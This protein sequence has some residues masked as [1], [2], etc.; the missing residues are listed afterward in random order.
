FGGR[1]SIQLGFAIMAVFVGLVGV[2]AGQTSL[3][4]FGALYVPAVLATAFVIGP[5]QTF[6]LSHLD[7]KS[8]PHGVTVISTSFQIA[9]GV[10]T[11]L[12]AGIYGMVSHS[13]LNAGTAEVDSLIVG[14]RAPVTLGILPS[15]IRLTIA[16]RAYPAPNPPQP[17][18]SASQDALPGAV[19]EVMKSEVY[20][21]NADSS[22]FEALY[23][24]TSLGISG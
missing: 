19:A 4:I 10:G 6:A 8:S 13:Q 1:W 7:E 5:S 16:I 15:V 23:S 14:V 21:T 12:A 11:S 3:V 17:Q 22:V 2:A 9:G 18:A 20:S 24:F